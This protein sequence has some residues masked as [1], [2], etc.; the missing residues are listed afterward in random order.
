MTGQRRLVLVLV[1]LALGAGWGL[2]MPLTKI[3]VSEG[4]KHFGLLFWQM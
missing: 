3:A 4:Y 2:T 1:L